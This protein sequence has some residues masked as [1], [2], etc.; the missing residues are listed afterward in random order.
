[1]Q[2]ICSWAVTRRTSPRR[3]L[4]FSGWHRVWQGI[5]RS[6]SCLNWSPPNDNGVLADEALCLSRED[7]LPFEQEVTVS[8]GFHFLSALISRR[9]DLFLHPRRA[10][11]NTLPVL[12]SQE[13]KKDGPGPYEY[14][15]Q[16]RGK[17]NKRFLFFF[18][19]AS[20]FIFSSCIPHELDSNFQWSFICESLSEERTPLLKRM[21]K[22]TGLKEAPLC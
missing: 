5:K 1:M 22:S 14:C 3:R 17:K 6:N 20:F 21:K 19:F 13:I 4:I 12:I 15:C 2:T 16:G 7:S 8:G 18:F 11:L 10:L 9:G